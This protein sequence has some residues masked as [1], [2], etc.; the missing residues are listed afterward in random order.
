MSA[1]SS[2]NSCKNDL[3]VEIDYT[4]L[5]VWIEELVNTAKYFR[6][7]IRHVCY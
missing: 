3:V 5:A 4:D 2:N 1:D 7:T 6:A